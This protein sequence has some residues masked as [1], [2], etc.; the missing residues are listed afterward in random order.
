MLWR[1]KNTCIS[2]N[3]F[4]CTSCSHSW[5]KGIIPSFQP[6]VKP[7]PFV[8]LLLSFCRFVVLSVQCF[9]FQTKCC[10]HPLLYETGK[11]CRWSMIGKFKQNGKFL[12]LWLMNYEIL[13][14]NNLIPAADGWLRLISLQVVSVFASERITK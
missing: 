1:N 2:W 5:P 7:F 8:L 11:I 6:M 10:C 12:F 4:K 3:F 13:S 14:E 9:C